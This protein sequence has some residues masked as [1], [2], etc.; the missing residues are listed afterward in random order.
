MK[1]PLL[2]STAVAVVLGTLAA[3]P[4]L[5]SDPVTTARLSALLR[6]HRHAALAAKRRT[7][8]RTV[9]SAG[10]TTPDFTFFDMPSSTDTEAGALNLGVG[11]TASKV[12]GCYVPNNSTTGLS[13]GFEYSLKTHGA[14][15][16]AT[17]D[18]IGTKNNGFC[19]VAI[20][21]SGVV[22]GGYY[23]NPTG[24]GPSP[25]FVDEG[26][27]LTLL[28]APFPN[29][30]GTFANAVNDAGTVVGDYQT[31]TDCNADA[32]WTEAGFI[33]SNGT[34]SP[35]AGPPGFQ[36]S[37]PFGINSAGDVVGGGLNAGAT[38]DVGWLLQGGVYTQVMV[39]GS[40]YSLVY[41]INDSGAM[42][43]AYCSTPADACLSDSP[44]EQA[45]L[46]QN[47]T[48]TTISVPG[49]IATFPYGINNQGEISGYYQD[50]NGYFHSFLIAP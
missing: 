44:P 38:A 29:V 12:V 42:V 19:P 33:W 45:F 11:G 46:Y 35:L 17:F 1:A 41:G 3:Q 28:Y 14:K 25:G 32:G 5:A 27:A 39:P 20:N 10:S 2:V 24:P 26:G 18:V 22:V 34:L 4:V 7:P 9:A 50:G 47:G 21:D 36:D 15:S 43:G 6:M 48:Y 40:V 30:C 37:I 16:T 49:A 31:N 8:V 13:N 23:P